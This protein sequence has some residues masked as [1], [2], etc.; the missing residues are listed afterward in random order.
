MSPRHDKCA[1]LLFTGNFLFEKQGGKGLI[2]LALAST[3]LNRE[4]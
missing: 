4:L 2:F 3:W 1:F